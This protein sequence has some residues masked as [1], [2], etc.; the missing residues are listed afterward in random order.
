MLRQVVIAESARHKDDDDV[1]TV[2]PPTDEP[3]TLIDT[4]PDEVLHRVT[5]MAARLFSAPIAAVSLVEGTNRRLVSH[6]G[7]NVE[8]HINDIDLSNSQPPAAESLFITD[9]RKDPRSKDSRLVKGPLGMRF[10][11]GAPL[12]LSDGTVIGTLSVINTSGYKPKADDMTS[13]EDLA[14]LVVAQL[15]MP[16]E[17]LRSDQV[18]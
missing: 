16:S 15:E 10:Y 13:L 17:G 7:E 12:K 5:A 14:A 6:F 2:V 11:A 8:D 3:E 1:P 18:F 4:I 9:A